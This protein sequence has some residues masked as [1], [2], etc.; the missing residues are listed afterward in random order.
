MPR[1]I[2][3]CASGLFALAASSKAER[4][5]SRPVSTAASC[6]SG[7]RMRSDGPG[8]LFVQ[9]CSARG[10]PHGNRQCFLVRQKLRNWPRFIGF[11][12]LCPDFACMLGR[13]RRNGSPGLLGFQ[14]L[15]VSGALLAV[16]KLRQLGA[17]QI[18]TEPPELRID[19]VEVNDADR[20]LPA[21]DDAQRLK[22][23]PAGHEN[24]LTIANDAR[25][26]RL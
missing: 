19:I 12:L 24:M 17:V 2:A 18:L 16:L 8:E 23:V 22:P 6:A 7:D 3:A 5:S 25:E 10:R 15:G 4:L 1:M 21:P 13:W 9:G 26:R 11:T 20:R 14:E